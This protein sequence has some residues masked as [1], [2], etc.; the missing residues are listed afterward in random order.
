MALPLEALP[1]ADRQHA[2]TLPSRATS[3]CFMEELD[4]LTA[5]APKLDPIV[6]S[7]KA[8]MMKLPTFYD[9]RKFL[10]LAQCLLTNAYRI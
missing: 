10:I 1:K 3:S 5:W 4:D 7:L 6:L 8:R 9:V 2:M